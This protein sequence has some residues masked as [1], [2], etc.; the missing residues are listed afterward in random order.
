MQNSP[1]ITAG[2]VIAAIVDD[3]GGDVESARAQITRVFREI[4]EEAIRE[5]RKDPRADI[6]TI[7]A[8]VEA[9]VFAS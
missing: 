3:H 4:V 7:T 8:R 9:I 1:K 5:A 6:A 2:D